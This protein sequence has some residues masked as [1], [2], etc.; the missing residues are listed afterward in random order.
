[1]TFMHR[2]RVGGRSSYGQVDQIPREEMGGLLCGLAASGIS[3]R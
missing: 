2:A 1:M 3:L